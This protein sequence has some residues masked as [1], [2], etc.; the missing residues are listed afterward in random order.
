MMTTP[1]PSTCPKRLL[2]L[3]ALL[4]GMMGCSGAEVMEY[5]HAD[6]ERHSIVGAP[7]ASIIVPKE[8]E[9]YAPTTWVWPTP[10]GPI[11]L[12]LRSQQE[13]AEGM[14]AYLDKE[15]RATLAGGEV[16]LAEDKRVMVGDLEGRLLEV[17]TLRKQDEPTSL[18][19]VVT[20]AED[21]MYTTG[22][23]GP[24]VAMKDR[25]AALRAFQLSL[26]VAVPTDKTELHQKPTAPDLVPPPDGPEHP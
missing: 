23:A 19:M 20:V 9:I 6:G 13:P 26:R 3:V 2:L 10:E 22:V 12:T 15:I 24:L 25:K 21:G 4:S 1:Q 11:L 18:W 14:D 7:N 16:G 8:C 17:N 5:P